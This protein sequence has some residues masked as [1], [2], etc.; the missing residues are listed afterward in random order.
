MTAT[1][2][3]PAAP[4]TIAGIALI[5]VPLIAVG[6]KTASFGWYMVLAIW[7]LY[8]PA[9]LLLGWILQI[10]V[11]ATACFGRR[12]RFA[13]RNRGRAIAAAWTTSLGVLA[14]ALCLVDGGDTTWGSTLM[15]WTGTAGDDAVG[16]LSTVLAW[17]A[18]VAW[19]GGWVWLV[20]EWIMALTRGARARH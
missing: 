18:L 17:A 4:L 6:V 1:D 12:A 2:V 20:V 16:T 8:V 15:Y 14:F 7:T 10:T 5:V 13:G 9:L 19:I 3:R 11:A